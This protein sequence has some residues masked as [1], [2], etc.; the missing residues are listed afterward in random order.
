MS[1]DPLDVKLDSSAQRAVVRMVHDLPE[2][3][4]NMVWRSALSDRLEKESRRVGRRRWFL[5]VGRPVAGLACTFGLAALVLV[6]GGV[7]PTPAPR[8]TMVARNFEASLVRAHEESQ[9]AFDVGGVGFGNDPVET[10]PASFEGWDES[11][12]EA[13]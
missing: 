9:I 3:T 11:D 5:H 13:F 8:P 2:D 12:V 7:T 10:A 4:P 6:R 1:H